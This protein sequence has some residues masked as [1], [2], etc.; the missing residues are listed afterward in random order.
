MEDSRV[1]RDGE[2]LAEHLGTEAGFEPA[3]E[4]LVAE[5]PCRIV[6]R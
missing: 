1:G 2:E 5:M 6:E 4:H 3:F